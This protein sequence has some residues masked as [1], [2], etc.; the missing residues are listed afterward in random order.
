MVIM[1]INLNQ[2]NNL[3]ADAD[4]QV[5]HGDQLGEQCPRCDSRSTKFC[6]YNNYS[7]TQ[8]RHYCKACRRHWTE[9][10]VCRNVPVGGAIRRNNRGARAGLARDPLNPVVAPRAPRRRGRGANAAAVAALAGRSVAMSGRVAGVQSD[11]G[12]RRII[13]SKGTNLLGFLGP[14]FPSMGTNFQNPTDARFSV[15]RRTMSA[16]CPLPL[17]ATSA[18]AA[19]NASN[20]KLLKEFSAANKIF[21]NENVSA[22]FRNFLCGHNGAIG[23]GSSD[24]SGSGEPP[25]LND[26][27]VA[28]THWTDLPDF[29]PPPPPSFA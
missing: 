20:L 23:S 7:L 24:G 12:H 8:P 28:N 25:A 15:F 26:M 27:N 22:G 11:R 14:N 18:S 3:G 17:L 4:D 9:G 13:S 1:D 19:M 10:G 29:S 6:Y 16:L 5:G 21:L 2:N